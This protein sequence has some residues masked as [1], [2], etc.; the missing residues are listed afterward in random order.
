MAGN[1]E[2]LREFGSSR[3]SKDCCVKGFVPSLWYDRA[4]EIFK[5]VSMEKGQ[6]IA[7]MHAYNG[8]V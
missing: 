8:D 4:V 3:S 5:V 6:A 7:G 2:G 1:V